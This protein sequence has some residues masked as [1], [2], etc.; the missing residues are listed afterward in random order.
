MPSESKR[1][2]A[3]IVF[4]D[5][6]GFTRLSAENAPAALGLLEKQR[7]LGLDWL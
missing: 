6:V 7:E 4:T 2:L 3:A 1:K 5:I